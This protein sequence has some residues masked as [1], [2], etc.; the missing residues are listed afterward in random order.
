MATPSND[1]SYMYQVQL[2]NDGSFVL[3]DF[4]NSTTD[5]ITPLP[6][7]TGITVSDNISDPV[8]GGGT[9]NPQLLGDAIKDEFTL[10]A[11]GDLASTLDGTYSYVSLALTSDASGPTDASHAGFIA[12]AGTN[13]YY[14]TNNLITLPATDSQSALTLTTE[15]G[16]T[17][18]CFMPNTHIQTPAGEV[19]VEDLTIGDLVQTHDGRC[20]PVRWIGRQ[21]VAGRFTDE[22][23]LPIRIRES[24]LSPNV[25]CRDLL[26][27]SD[28]A[29][30]VDDVLINAGALINGTSIVRELKVP[31][32]FT[33]YHVELD[34]HSLVM[35][36]NTPAETFVDNV[37]RANFDNWRE[38]Q[39]LYPEGKAV[40]EMPYP[41]AKAS[42]Q[43]PRAIR[44]R[45]VDRGIS[46][47]GPQAASAA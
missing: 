31:V 17:A 11:G 42:R 35:A 33:Y 43:V 9:D 7:G 30:L 47:F 12:Q 26:V 13:Y 25:P 23:R 10:T 5:G 27:S 3:K 44:E 21:T 20:L 45:L 16:D 39:A 22:R 4:D 24:A 36:E 8:S 14:I 1:F 29:L 40:R 15:S 38:Y 18:I 41:R 6:V 46:L 37:D 34:D 32:I 2:Q 28:H 19:M